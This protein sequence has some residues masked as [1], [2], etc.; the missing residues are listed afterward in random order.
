MIQNKYKILLVEDEKNV[1]NIV[2]TMLETEGYQTILA[3]SC[4][5]AKTLFTSYLPELVILDLGLP[6]MDGMNFLEFVRKDSLIPIIVLSARTNESDK[7]AALDGGANDYITKPF[8][9]GELLARVRA[10]LRNNR[11]SADEGR[12]PGGKFTLKNLEIDYDARQVFIKGEEIHLTQTEYNIVALLSEN[13]GK[14]ITYAAIIKATWGDYPTENNIK[15]LQVNM[16]NIR[17]KF[18][19][20]PGEQNYIANELGVGYRLNT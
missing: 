6:D 4:S 17:K 15:K 11:F 3:N 14:M 10:A 5:S 16:A 13:C 20:K 2:A 7:I 1:R 12:L 8:S 18:G 19:D 9:S